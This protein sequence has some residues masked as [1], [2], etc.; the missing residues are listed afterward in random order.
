MDWS[1]DSVWRQILLVLGAIV[2]TL[3]VVVLFYWI[4]SPK[5]YG[6]PYSASAVVKDLFYKPSSTR[7]GVGYGMT[8]NGQ[9][10]TV[11]T[12][13]TEEES[14]DVVFVTDDNHVIVASDKQ[15]YGSLEKGDRAKLWLQPM[16]LFG[17]EKD[18]EYVRFE[19]A[20]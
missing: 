4:F 19:K 13:S 6:E 11:V 14:F 10:G 17:K 18:A 9:M 8:S 15:A 16:R 7:S 20:Q 12:T 1:D 3:A 2:L 5:P